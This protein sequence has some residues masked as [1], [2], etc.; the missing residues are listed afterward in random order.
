MFNRLVL[1]RAFALA[2]TSP[3]SDKIPLAVVSAAEGDPGSSRR[4]VSLAGEQGE[5]RARA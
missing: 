4:Q 3:A 2:G 1:K 5:D